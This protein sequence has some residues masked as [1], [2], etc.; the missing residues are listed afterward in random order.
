MPQVD[1]HTRGYGPAF[2]ARMKQ[3]PYRKYNE[4]D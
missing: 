2:Y 1:V 3:S 4:A